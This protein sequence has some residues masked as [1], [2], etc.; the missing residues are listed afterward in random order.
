MALAPFAS[1]IGRQ[2]LELGFFV[3]S[4]VSGGDWIHMGLPALARRNFLESLPL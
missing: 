4:F 1:L 2:W 3:L